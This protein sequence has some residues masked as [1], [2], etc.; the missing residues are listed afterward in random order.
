VTVGVTRDP[1]CGDVVSPTVA[2]PDVS[3]LQA[4]SVPVPHVVWRT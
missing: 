1:R 3:S 2:Q 4:T